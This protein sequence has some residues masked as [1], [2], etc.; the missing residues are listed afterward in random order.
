MWA[1]L[2]LLRYC[3]RSGRAEMTHACDD[4]PAY[5]AVILLRIIDTLRYPLKVR[6][7]IHACRGG[8]V[9]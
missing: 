8:M 9:R 6:I 1:G 5:N 4:Q 2:Y 3:E 7:V